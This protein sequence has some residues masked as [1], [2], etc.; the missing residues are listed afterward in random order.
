MKNEPFN[1]D[2]KKNCFQKSSISNV[3]RF[4]QP[5]YLIP[6]W[7]TETGSLKTYDKEYTNEGPKSATFEGG[8]P[9][10]CVVLAVY[11]LPVSPARLCLSLVP[12]VSPWLDIVSWN[13]STA[14]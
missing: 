1:D 3:K 6:R 7:K 14:A 9:V 5:K 11:R 8:V 10:S 2:L 13:N 4:S 12:A